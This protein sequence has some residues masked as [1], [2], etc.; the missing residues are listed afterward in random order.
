MKN[1]TLK[2]LAE[3]A[4]VS[5]TTVS[6]ALSD[7]PVISVKRRQAIKKLAGEY[8]Y[9]PNSFAKSLVTRKSF[10]IGLFFTSLG[11]NVTPAFFHEITVSVQRIIKEK[12]NLI[13]R[14]IDDYKHDFS[15]IDKGNFDGILL[16]SQGR[17]D[18]SFI[19]YLT[20]MEMPLVVINRN[21]RE[22][23]IDSF[24]ADER[25]V[26]KE[27][28]S[29]LL[30]NGHLKIAFVKG[31]A[32]SISAARRYSGYLEAM[33]DTFGTAT[34]MLVFEGDYTTKSGYETGRKIA[35]M[36]PRPTAAICSNDDMAVG[37]IKSF[38]DSGIKV[39]EDISVT[40]F[41]N[42]EICEYLIPPLTTVN[43]Q[44]DLIVKS[45]AERLLEKLENTNSPFQTVTKSYKSEL[46][47][48]KSVATL[49]E[50]QKD[51]VKSCMKKK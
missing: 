45:A 15:G 21:M 51:T 39:P 23:N 22:F 16:V 48:R 19:N 11:A 26:I 5:H 14:G 43:R 2:D 18:D 12:Y 50:A 34:E 31:A 41:D 40:G 44:T 32:G 7:N 36:K 4:G 49:S 24:F 37:L 13:I 8:G 47:I 33:R 3:I 1:L 17:K 38:N 10:N 46:I 9:R 30:K 27:T 35:R 6:R 20:E 29:Y 42:M 28:V 25:E